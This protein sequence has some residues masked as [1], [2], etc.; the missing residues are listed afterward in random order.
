MDVRERIRLLSEL[1]ARFNTMLE[2]AL[3]HVAD[4]AEREELCVVACLVANAA[5][6]FWQC[7][8]PP[9]DNR[10]EHEWVVLANIMRIAESEDLTL[11]EKRIA[12]AFAFTHDSCFIRRIMEASIRDATDEERQKLKAQKREQRMRHMEG[13]AKNA[14]FLLNQLTRPESPAELLLARDEIERCVQIVGHHDF[15]KLDGENP[16]ETQDRLALTCIEGDALWPLHPIGVLADLERPD[17]HGHT[18]DF[19]DPA[20]WRTQLRQSLKTL[21]T[22]F[23]PHWTH[24]R[25]DDFRDHESIFRTAGGY[26]LYRAWR[27]HWNL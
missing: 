21:T 19:S 4:T 20:I 24:I 27:D 23:R 10:R 9:E 6:K 11:S 5:W 17:R 16:P 14:A 8:R 1:P 15:W 18:Q 26:D 13:G 22:S 7:H 2:Q 3:C 12:T 25:Q